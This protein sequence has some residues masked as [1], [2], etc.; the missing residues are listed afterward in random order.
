MIDL[1]G[2]SNIPETQADREWILQRYPQNSVLGR[3]HRQLYL[4][5]AREELDLLTERYQRLAG[6]MVE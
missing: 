4:K 1:P 5:D 3:L 2:W 6:D